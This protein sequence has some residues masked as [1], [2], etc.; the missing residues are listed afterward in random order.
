MDALVALTEQ[1]SSLPRMDSPLHRLANFIDAVGP[2]LRVTYTEA[3]DV[4]AELLA[5][6]GG[7]K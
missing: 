5:L 4:D 6:V 3:S 7:L 1:S 2:V